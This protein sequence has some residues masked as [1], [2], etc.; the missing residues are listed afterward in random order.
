MSLDALLRYSDGVESSGRANAF[1]PAADNATP[2]GE[3]HARVTLANTAFHHTGA[4]VV[5]VDQGG[6]GELNLL[7]DISQGVFGNPSRG[8][9]A[10]RSDHL[11]LT[12]AFGLALGGGGA[13]IEALAGDWS[14]AEG[15]S[16]GALK[17][18]AENIVLPSGALKGVDVA[19]RGSMERYGLRWIVGCDQLQARGASATVNLDGT[20]FV[21]TRGLAGNE[22]LDV[23]VPPVDIAPFADVVA[24]AAGGINKLGDWLTGLDPRGHLDSAIGRID[25][26]D[27]T[28]S[29]AASVSGVELEDFKGI[30]Y[31]RNGAATIAGTEHA[32]D[33]AVDDKDI[34]LGFLNFYDAPFRLDAASGELLVWFKPGYLALLGRNLNAVVGDMTAKG[35]VCARPSRRPSR[36]TIPRDVAR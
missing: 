4:V 36:T 24:E 6:S 34:A 21:L 33:I 7:Y 17:L 32:L 29:Y 13:T 25:L 15:N 8:R 16:T 11:T 9:I 1:M 18:S 28:L 35:T 31:M 5:R 3:L 27:R 23:S 20:T 14:F 30:P 12:P 19:A 26:V 10:L 2:L 22:R